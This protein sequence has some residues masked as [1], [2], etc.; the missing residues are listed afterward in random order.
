MRKRAALRIAGLL[1]DHQA[2]DLDRY[3]G[4]HRGPPPH[5]LVHAIAILAAGDVDLSGIDLFAETVELEAAERIGLGDDSPFALL[6]VGGHARI[7]DADA[8]VDVANRTD[9]RWAR[10]R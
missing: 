4:L 2:I 1:P 5:D 9:E 6:D 10:V 3:A 8:F 7:L